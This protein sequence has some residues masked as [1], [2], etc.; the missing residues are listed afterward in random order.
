MKL[1]NNLKSRYTFSK[2]IVLNAQETRHITRSKLAKE[3][4]NLSIIRCCVVAE[5]KSEQKFIDEL[6][7]AKPKSAFEVPEVPEIPEVP[8]VPEVPEDDD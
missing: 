4:K 5:S 6:L 8:E 1:V 2:N 7:K 3:I